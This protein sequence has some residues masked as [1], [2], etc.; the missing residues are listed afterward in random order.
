MSILDDL[1][2]DLPNLRGNRVRRVSVRPASIKS[3]K[4]IV[5]NRRERLLNVWARAKISAFQRNRKVTLAQPD[6]EEN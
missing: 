3:F 2:E 5:K 1:E 6:S 4:K